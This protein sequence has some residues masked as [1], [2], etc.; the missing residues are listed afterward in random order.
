M[1]GGPHKQHIH[2]QWADLQARWRMP[3][4]V[5]RPSPHLMYTSSTLN[6][7]VHIKYIP[8]CKKIKKSF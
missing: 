7:C 2:E 5:L 6:P 4:P 8:I 3:S 1:P